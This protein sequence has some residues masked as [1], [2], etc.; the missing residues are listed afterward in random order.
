[1][2]AI[3]ALKP[4]LGAA[5]GSSY[6]A[7]SV[8]AVDLDNDLEAGIQFLRE[9]AGG[10]IDKAFDQVSIGGSWLN[11]QIVR[12]VWKSHALQPAS[13][14]LLLVERRVDA[15]AYVASSSLSV[16]DDTIVAN[17]VGEVQI[18]EWMKHGQP[19]VSSSASPP[20]QA[21]NPAL[22]SAN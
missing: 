11:E 18:V 2:K 12:L 22:P 13:P 14:Q 3:Q 8:V 7:I 4:S 15:D 21:A 19:L 17:L 16:A 20:E 6:A 1:M 9:V 5:H 10:K